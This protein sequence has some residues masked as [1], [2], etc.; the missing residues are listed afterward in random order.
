MTTP[1]CLSC[2]L[3]KTEMENDKVR[4]LEFQCPKLTATTGGGDYYDVEGNFNDAGAIYLPLV[5]IY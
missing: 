4:G 1:W 3:P 2:G 5:Y